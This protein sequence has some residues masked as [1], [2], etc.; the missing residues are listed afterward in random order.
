MAILTETR[1]I[2]AKTE[3]RP[4][5]I[6]CDMCGEKSKR[7]NNWGDGPYSVNDVTIEHKT[8]ESYPEGGS[9]EY[10]R[11]DLCP[12]CFK[13]KLVPWLESQGASVRQEEWD[14]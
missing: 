6:Q 9:G 2:P 11:C 10:L 4:V 8:G 3:T 13:T 12:T 5:S 14:W 7:S 1:Q